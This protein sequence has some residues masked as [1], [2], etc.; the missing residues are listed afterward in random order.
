MRTS[1]VQADLRNRC[2]G[3]GGQTVA[4]YWAP[5]TEIAIRSPVE[6]PGP[7]AQINFGKSQE[8]QSGYSRRHRWEITDSCRQASIRP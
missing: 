4:N 8:A 6:A 5:K 2:P 7:K 1:K 3:G